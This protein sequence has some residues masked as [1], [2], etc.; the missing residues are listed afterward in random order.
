MKCFNQN[1]TFLL[2]ILPLSLT[3][4]RLS[5]V[6]ILNFSFVLKFFSDNIDR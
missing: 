5:D 6:T 1:D 2:L 3:T 4:K